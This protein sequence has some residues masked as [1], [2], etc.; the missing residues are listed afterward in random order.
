MSFTAKFVEHIR[1][2]RPDRQN[3]LARIVWL[4]SSR[5]SPAQDP[6]IDTSEL[7]TL[8]PLHYGLVM[9]LLAYTGANGHQPLSE[10]DAADVQRFMCVNPSDSQ[11]LRSDT[12]V[13]TD[14]K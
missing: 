4:V 1:A 9:F 7:L 12:V 8:N 2:A 11:G 10:E 5:M 13:C 6:P 14:S 3:L